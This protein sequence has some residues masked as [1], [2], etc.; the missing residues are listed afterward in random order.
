M[1]V[2]IKE[3]L[4]RRW[5][6]IVPALVLAG[7][8]FWLGHRAARWPIYYENE[9]LFRADTAEVADEICFRK[10][11]ANAE[12]FVHPLFTV[13]VKPFGEALYELTRSVQTPSRLIAGGL[14]I[15][16]ALFFGACMRGAG[17][18]A[19]A[20]ACWTLLYGLSATPSVFS[21]IPERYSFGALSQV[22]VLWAVVARR[23][24]NIA[25]VASG[26]L[27]GGSALTNL[28]PWAILWFFARANDLPVR[29]WLLPASR[30]AGWS[31]VVVGL[32]FATHFLGSLHWPDTWFARNRKMMEAKGRFLGQSDSVKALT[33]RAD[34]LVRHLLW[35]PIAPPQPVL[36]VQPGGETVFT[37][38]AMRHP[39]AAKEGITAGIAWLILAGAGLIAWRSARRDLKMI[40]AGLVA[41][42][43]FH[44][45]LHMQYGDDF[46]L[47]TSHWMGPLLALAA[48]PL[49]SRKSLLACYG[50]PV[51]AVF[52]AIATL[53][54]FRHLEG[55]ISSNIKE[56]WR[57]EQPA[58]WA[59]AE[60]MAELLKN[61]L[62]TALYI[63]RFYRY[64]QYPLSSLGIETA[65]SLF[66]PNPAKRIRA[67]AAGRAAVLEP[68]GN[69][70]NF[71]ATTGASASFARIG[72]FTIA[73]DLNPSRILL[74]AL[75]LSA[76]REIQD[77]EGRS[78]RTAL[79]DHNIY[80]SWSSRDAVGDTYL[81]IEFTGKVAGAGV[82]ILPVRTRN[83]AD[84]EVGAWDERSGA[85]QTLTEK[86]VNHGFSWEA[87]RVYVGGFPR[88]HEA[89]F[90]P[91]ETTAL[92]LTVKSG[93]RDSFLKIAGVQI[94]APAQGEDHPRYNF[95]RL[96]ELLADSDRTRIY[97]DRFI[98]ARLRSTDT[99][100]QVVSFQSEHEYQR[101]YAP[102]HARFSLDVIPTD[103]SVAFVVPIEEAGSIRE[104]LNRLGQAVEEHDAG[105]WRVFFARLSAE[106]ELESYP[107]WVAG[108]LFEDPFVEAGPFRNNSRKSILASFRGVGRLHKVSLFPEDI[109]PGQRGRLETVWSFNRLPSNKRP[110]VFV[111]FLREGEL[112]FQADHALLQDWSRARM[113]LYRGPVRF[114]QKV[115][116]NVPA[117]A[118]NGP[119]DMHIG[120]WLPDKGRRIRPHT[121]YARRDAAVVLAQALRVEGP[122]LRPSVRR[123][124]PAAHS[125]TRI[126]ESEEDDDGLEVFHD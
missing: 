111:H 55:G 56:I 108:R 97:A 123:E 125:S 30:V 114:K 21:S 77:A 7:W 14:G 42:L 38:T 69:F 80:T 8:Y 24:S 122:P 126:V 44:F 116:F 99:R 86:V 32:L 11:P 72:S 117:D 83:L 33:D 110:G 113:R 28:A 25:L 112:I 15:L 67:E 105:A 1:G 98:S 46:F 120:V 88:F 49:V 85:W 66:E 12:A 23:R 27:S 43:L 6:P 121:N 53:G 48:L 103:S 109:R 22:V 29:R 54:L 36:V 3:Y 18:D 73:H 37:F 96:F 68:D 78:W 9:L 62:T 41:A 64:L 100:H 71:L 51:T 5:I 45:A 89:R 20:A 79:L 63:P 84:W 58:V 102:R 124:L 106:D 70:H 76:V 52:A 59:T 57:R 60:S 90:T 104:V 95:E 10:S 101:P 16:A 81:T 92:R 13:L 2:R 82:R 74:H 75:P 61:E 115:Y 39:P 34:R 50:P 65:D 91:V 119:Y 4:L 40:G 118:P 107:V 19:F 31:V 26:L 94:Y 17:A 35:Y 47:Y 93:P 87:G